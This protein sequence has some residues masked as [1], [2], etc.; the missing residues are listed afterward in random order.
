M[1]F[2]FQI[3]PAKHSRILNLIS[4]LVWKIEKLPQ[5]ISKARKFPILPIFLLPIFRL[6]PLKLDSEDHFS[7]VKTDVPGRKLGSMVTNNELFHLL[8]NG[9]VLGVK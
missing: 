4:N 9:V 6:A 8:I 2:L 1:L 7:T 3:F 5:K